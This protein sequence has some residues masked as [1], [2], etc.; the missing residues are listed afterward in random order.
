MSIW[1]SGRAG[2]NKKGIN[3]EMWQC[4]RG[5][6]K[7]FHAIRDSRTMDFKAFYKMSEPMPKVEE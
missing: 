3:A 2:K 5:C 1:L 6:G 7:W 4:L